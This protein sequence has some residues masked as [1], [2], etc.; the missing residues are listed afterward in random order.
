MIRTSQCPICGLESAEILGLRFNVKMNLPTDVAIRYCSSDNF[1][2]VAS[3]DQHSY[4]EYYKALAND[5]YHAEL[6][7]N[8][9]HS[10]IAKLQLDRLGKLLDGFLC[11]PKRVL[12]FGCGE[13]W[14][15]VELASEYPS[16]TFMGFDPSPAARIGSHRVQRLGLQNVVISD[17]A[18]SN[19]PYDLI[20]ASHV[21]EH[22]IEFDLLDFWKTLLAENGILYIEVPNSLLYATHQRRE[23]LYYFD[24]IHVNHFTAQ[25]LGKLL[26]IHGFGHVGSFE[27]EFP[28]RDGSQY[29]ALGMLFQKGLEP[30]EILSQNLSR[31]TAQYL[32][33]ENRR[34]KALNE[35]LKKFEGVLVWGAGDNFYRS[36]QNGGPLSDL[37]NMVVL[38]TRP[39]VVVL[40]GRKWITETPAE[41]I[42]RYS[43]PVVITVS[44][45]SQAIRE[46]VKEID[47]S[48]QILF[49]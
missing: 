45:S 37:P 34:A 46:Q 26:A 41:G 5:S 11:E 6:A 30:T 12:D 15:L 24:R 7:G 13:G 28:Y 39:Q 31:T 29:P 19:G 32:S 14:L 9:S 43:W 38:D 3:G 21:V 49:V 25:S 36:S 42:R 8:A 33:E 17:Q 44:A 20:I 40:D 18:P 23:F 35:Q 2:F 27:Y 47:P 10:P 16:S 22:L 48:R 4:E 1:L